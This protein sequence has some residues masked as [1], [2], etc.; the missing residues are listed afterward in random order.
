EDRRPQEPRAHL[1]KSN[2]R[3]RSNT[4]QPVSWLPAP[5][6][7]TTSAIKQ[8]TASAGSSHP[9]FSAPNGRPCR[10]SCGLEDRMLPR[11]GPCCLGAGPCCLAGRLVVLGGLA[12]AVW[13]TGPRSPT[14][15]TWNSASRL[16]ARV[17]LSQ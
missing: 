9:Q 4:E 10:E 1:E 3:A 16:V 11:A 14:S 5:G 17:R 7:E 13:R 15:C 6:L 12:S 8:S 2:P